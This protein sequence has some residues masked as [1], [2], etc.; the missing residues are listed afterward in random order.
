MVIAIVAITNAGDEA[1]RRA[2]IEPTRIANLRTLAAAENVEFIDAGAALWR[3][4]ISENRQITDFLP[5]GGNPNDAGHAVYADAIKASLDPRLET[6]TGLGRVESRYITQTNLQDARIVATSAVTANTCP[7]R[8]LGSAF[9]NSALD[10]AAGQGFT[11]GF[12]G[13]SFGFIRGLVSNGGQLECTVD[14][15][16][17]TNEVFFEAGSDQVAIRSRLLY[18]GLA[19]AAHTATCRAGTTSPSGSTG[20]RVVVGRLPG[21]FGPADHQPLRAAVQRRRTNCAFSSAML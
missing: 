16:L 5:D 15:T 2:G 12:T 19:N 14:G 9:I 7:V 8:D 17:P 20:T 18:M 10:C 4:V 1:N 3:K 11:F 21:Q 13:T 6:L